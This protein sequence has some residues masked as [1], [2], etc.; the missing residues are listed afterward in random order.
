MTLEKYSSESF[1]SASFRSIAPNLAHL[2]RAQFPSI[3]DTL[4]GQYFQS[5]FFRRPPPSPTQLTCSAQHISNNIRDN[6]SKNIR[7]IILNITS[8]YNQHHL[9]DPL[10]PTFYQSYFR[11]SFAAQYL[12]LKVNG[13]TRSLAYYSDIASIMLLVHSLRESR[14]CR[15]KSSSDTHIRYLQRV[16]NSGSV[17]DP[18]ILFLCLWFLLFL[19]LL[20]DPVWSLHKI[21]FP[22]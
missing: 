18:E 22:K 2:A 4:W 17:V 7:D 21:C 14:I 9:D 16:Q 8:N 10:W 11:F 12:Q 19:D 15:N 6:I 13:T 20:E 5:A 1:Q 3:F